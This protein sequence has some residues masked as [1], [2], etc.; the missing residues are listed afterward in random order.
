MLRL[1]L[2]PLDDRPVSVRLPAQVARVAGATVEVPP[3]AHRPRLRHAPDVAALSA[4]YAGSRG[5]TDASV[6][7]LDGL[8]LGSLIASRTG[9]ERLDEVLAAWRPVTRPGPPVHAAIVVPRTPDSAD[10][11]EEPDYWD[12]HGP[13]LHRLSAELGD[14]TATLDDARS[15]VAADVPAD[16]V[17]D[18]TGRRLRQH[19]L[20]LAALDLHR[21]GL[22]TT[23]VVGVDDAA[24]RSLSALAQEDL[25]RWAGLLGTGHRAVVHPGA[26]ETGAVLVARAVLAASAVA[27]PRVAVRCAADDGLDRV[28]PYETGP[29]GHTAVRQ[30]E[31]AG[32][33]VVDPRS[34]DVDCH[35][36]VHAPATGPSAG[37]WAVAPP[38]GSDGA[39]ATATAGTVAELLAAGQRV[40]VADVAQP[41]GADPALVTALGE[42]GA[43]RRL[44]GYAAWNTAGNTLGTVAAQVVATCAAQAAGTFDAAA[45]RELLA[46]RVAEDAG[47]MSHARARARAELGSDPT[48]HDVVRLTADRRHRWE[49]LV[50]EVLARTPGLDDARVVPGSLTLP[51]DRTFEIDLDVEVAR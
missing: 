44:V 19:A 36:V 46:H 9:T 12:P 23:L 14:T 8:G 32:A 33:V 31:A 5:R 42:V 11:T 3:P 41:N 48:R 28:A 15:R 4:W 38:A 43:W 6:V 22:L 13:A 35:V 24:Q 29:V 51:W 27:P 21:R 30:L 17:A 40:A 20:A 10:A 18:W 49:S 7:S 50:G 26:D 2:L 1:T 37:D 47:W 16:V 39:A 25:A 34:P 45:H